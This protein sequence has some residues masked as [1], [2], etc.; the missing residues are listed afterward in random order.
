MNTIIS[1]WSIF[2]RGLQLLFTFL[3]FRLYEYLPPGIVRRLFCCLSFLSPTRW[4]AEIQQQNLV[5]RTALA[6]QKLGPV[7]IKFGQMLSTRHD[8]INAETAKALA[9]L[10]DQMPYFPTSLAKKLIEDAFGLP[11]ESLFDRFD[12]KPLAAASIAQIHT[13]SLSP[14]A[15]PDGL[16]KEVIIKLIRP[17]VEASIRQETHVLKLMAKLANRFFPELERF[18]VL[19]VVE[20]YETTILAECDLRLE[21]ANTLRFAADFEKSP[22]L[23]VPRIYTPWVRQ[24]A[25]IME[26]VSGLPVNDIDGLVAAGV[27]LS[28]LSEIGAT[29]FLTQVFKNNFFHADMHPGNILVDISNPNAPRYIAIDCAIAGTLDS[30]DHRLLTRKL[31]ALI[32]QDYHRLARLLIAGRWVPADTNRHELAKALE[33]VCSPILS[34]PLS[35]IEFGPLLAELFSTA[36]KFELQAL[37]QFVLLEKTLLHVEGLGRQLDPD[38]DIWSLGQPLL[39]GWLKEDLLSAKT[40]CTAQEKMVSAIEKMPEALED[41]YDQQMGI[42]QSPAEAI[43]SRLK[44]VEQELAQT[45][46][47]R[48]FQWYAAILTVLGGASLYFD[49][50]VDIPPITAVLFGIAIWCLKPAKIQNKT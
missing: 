16:S 36:R 15:S 22:L 29:I 9:T 44:R 31:L 1:T 26:R 19:Q 10:Q 2:R 6:F 23:Y 48:Q 47:H 5:N 13:A 34:K 24:T 43:G 35:E 42:R 18:H 39:S 45:A 11:I 7:A 33:I 12:E 28:Q 4:N 38:L 25:F 8:L 41:W 21:A 32:Q 50:F 17:G 30:R 27:S 46:K 49:A 40:I 37:P 20:D 14:N 3:G